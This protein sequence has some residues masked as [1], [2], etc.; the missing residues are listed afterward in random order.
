MKYR[1]GDKVEIIDQSSG[2]YK[3]K[4]YVMIKREINDKIWIAFPLP[5]QM[6][7]VLS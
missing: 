5:N 4:G 7:M 3:K 6:E 1:E 2:F